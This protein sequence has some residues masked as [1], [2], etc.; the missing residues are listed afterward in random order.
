MFENKIIKVSNESIEN[1]ISEKQLDRRVH[2]VCIDGKNIQTKNRFFSMMERKFRF[3]TCNTNWN[4]FLDWMRDLEW[5][6]KREYILVIYNYNSFLAYDEEFKEMIMDDFKKIILPYW[7]NDAKYYSE[8]GKPSPFNI[9]IDD[10]E[11]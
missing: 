7:E 1:I 11:S 4:G 5:L 3:P 2:I 10:K 8:D 6:K 9:Y